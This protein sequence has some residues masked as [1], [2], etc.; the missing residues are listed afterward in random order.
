MF[1]FLSNANCNGVTM[2]F[3]QVVYC[4]MFVAIYF[5]LQG[6]DGNY[7]DFVLPIIL[8]AIDALFMLFGY[9]TFAMTRS[10]KDWLDK[11]IKNGYSTLSDELE[12]PLKN[13]V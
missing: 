6:M 10:A 11:A 2:L 5:A 9:L 13:A 4:G 12:D 1:V 3:M 7:E 8:S